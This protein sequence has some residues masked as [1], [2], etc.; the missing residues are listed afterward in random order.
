MGTDVCLQ[1]CGMSKLLGAHTTVKGTIPSVYPVVSL[2]MSLLNK[3]HRAEMALEGPLLCWEIPDG[4]R[5]IPDTVSDLAAIVAALAVEVLQLEPCTVLPEKC[6][7][8]SF[9]PNP[10]DTCR[11]ISKNYNKSTDLATEEHSKVLEERNADI[12]GKAHI[13]ISLHNGRED[14]SH[15]CSHAPV[16]S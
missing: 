15:S 6:T 1:V 8:G 9:L 7:C 14:I 11:Q 4:R 13:T 2:Q 3:G 5:G 10:A 16:S 12:K